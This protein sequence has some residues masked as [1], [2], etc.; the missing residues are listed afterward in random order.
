MEQ[1]DNR[2]DMEKYIDTLENSNLKGMAIVRMSL[3]NDSLQEQQIY[4]EPEGNIEFLE[5]GA[6][7]DLVLVVRAANSRLSIAISEVGLM[8]T[9]DWYGA[10]F[11]DGK[12][13][14]NY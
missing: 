4:L 7:F 12:G 8:I 13:I 5:P 3:K 14:M 1:Q 9:P 10:I 2:T 11:Q 6:T